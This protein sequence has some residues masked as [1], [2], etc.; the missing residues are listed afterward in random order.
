[1]GFFDDEVALERAIPGLFGEELRIGSVALPGAVEVLRGR[2]AVAAGHRL[3]VELSHRTGQAGAMDALDLWLNAP[4]ARTKTPYLVLVGSRDAMNS[5]IIKPNDLDGAV[6]IYEYRIAGQG[7]G[8]LA[9]DDMNGDRT[10]IAPA[11]LRTRVAEIACRKL[12]ENGARLALVSLAGDSEAPQRPLADSRQSGPAFRLA[13]R[14]RMVPRYLPLGPTLEST[15]ATLGKHTRRNLRYYRRRVEADLGAKFIPRVEM[16]RDEF[17]EMNQA[18]IN[19][20]PA[21]IAAWHYEA[22]RCLVNPVFCGVRTADGRWLSLI[23]GRR[24]PGA[25]DI[26]WQMNLAGLPRYS[27]STATRAFLLEDEIARG[28]AKLFFE[29]GTPHPMRHSFASTG[30]VDVIMQRR[31]ASVWLLRALS[32]WIFPR[33]NFLAQTLRDKSLRWSES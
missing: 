28:T 25:V 5:G 26:D 18:S 10:V 24:R 30:V 14:K 33:R 2:R 1:M 9:T 12:L 4:S 8:V 16:S 19:P 13:M 32:R 29:G 3:L 20:L 17:L 31:S 7:T 15:L 6:L 22:T 11:E 27:L 23:G 21:A